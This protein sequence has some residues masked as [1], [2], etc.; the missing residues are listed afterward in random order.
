VRARERDR[1]RGIEAAPD[2]EMQRRLR[3]QMAGVAEVVVALEVI[4]HQPPDR[5]AEQRE[6]SHSGEPIRVPAPTPTT[7]PDA[8]VHAVGI[9]A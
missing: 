3:R 4:R 9:L 5:P 2:L 6:H 8:F 1:R 7:P